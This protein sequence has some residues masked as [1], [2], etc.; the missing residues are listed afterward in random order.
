MN[1]Y[2]KEVK[3]FCTKYGVKIIPVYTGHRKYFSDDKTARACYSVTI[4]RKGKIPYTFDFGQSLQDSY[5]AKDGHKNTW[6][7]KWG[8]V[9]QHFNFENKELPVI[10][11]EEKT[12]RYRQFKTSP[13]HEVTIRQAIIPPTEYDILAAV[14]KNDPGT[15]DD[16]CADY[17]YDTDSKKAEQTY[18]AVQK[19]WSNINRLFADCMEELQEIS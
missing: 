1:D 13:T 9:P 5:Q 14:T 4:E 18:F 2:Q 10:A 11:K 19:E 16:F 8:K 15:F 7:Q 3:E 12:F 17:G 6:S